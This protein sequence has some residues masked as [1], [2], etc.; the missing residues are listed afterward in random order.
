ML[1]GKDGLQVEICL[2][3]KVFLSGWNVAVLDDAGAHHLDDFL[4]QRW[5]EGLL[6]T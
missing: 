3:L 4:S 1:L 5:W 2:P 6:V